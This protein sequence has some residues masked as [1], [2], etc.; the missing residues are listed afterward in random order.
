MSD[1][2][3]RSTEIDTLLTELSPDDPGHP[4]QDPAA[5]GAGGG[6]DGPD[7]DESADRP[8]DAPKS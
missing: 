3:P 2:P 5:G 1:H 6:A 7:D 8:L 4:V